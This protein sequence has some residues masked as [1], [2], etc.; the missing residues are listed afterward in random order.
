MRKESHTG[1]GGESGASRKPVLLKPR[2]HSR[3]LE[4]TLGNLGVELWDFPNEDA[5]P[6]A[7]LRFEADG[8]QASAV[9]HA[10]ERDQ[11]RLGVELDVMQ[12]GAIS[13]AIEQ[14]M[15]SFESETRDRSIPSI[16]MQIGSLS[17]TLFPETTGQ[18][19]SAELT[20]RPDAGSRAQA[21]LTRLEASLLGTLLESLVEDEEADCRE[22]VG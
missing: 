13:V 16:Q 19:A 21:V 1:R 9:G 4:V 8:V 10:E 15:L 18:K 7:R 14:W 6:Y 20:L 12:A 17:I 3:C 5:Q 22:F 11:T 2:G